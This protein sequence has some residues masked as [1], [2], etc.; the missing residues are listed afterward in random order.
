MTDHPNARRIHDLFAAFRATFE[1]A[2]TADLILHVVDAADPSRG[3]H[4]IA[5]TPLGRE[6]HYYP[7]TRR[8][9]RRDNEPVPTSA[10]V[11]DADGALV[12][13]GDMKVQE[14]RFIEFQLPLSP[15]LE[16]ARTQL[17]VIING[18]ALHPIPI[19]FI[20]KPMALAE[21]RYD[22]PGRLIWKAGGMLPYGQTGGINGRA[23]GRWFKFD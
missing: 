16:P 7:V 13:Q 23:P 10:F 2:T 17:R 22:G 4:L 14:R 6:K 11:E 20:G 9:F 12:F 21:Y 5:A 19:E 8:H 18:H 15:E 3:D 1:E